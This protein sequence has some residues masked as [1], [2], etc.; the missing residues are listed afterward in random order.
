MQRDRFHTAWSVETIVCDSYGIAISGNRR[1]KR[2]LIYLR[3]T[4]LRI[5]IT[6][7]INDKVSK[8]T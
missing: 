5:T 1:F 3:I 4:L 8:A 6:I 2:C 7:H